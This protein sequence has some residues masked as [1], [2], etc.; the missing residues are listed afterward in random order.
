[1]EK[2]L[3]DLVRALRALL[4]WLNEIWPPD[5]FT[6]ESGDPGAVRVATLREQATAALAA[7]ENVDLYDF[8]EKFLD[9]LSEQMGFHDSRDT[10]AFAQQFI[11]H[12]CHAKK[13]R[14]S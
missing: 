2:E 8:P 9:W 12:L 5:I 1:M 6:G 10:E 13:G 3:E 7:V 4:D 11:V 14:R